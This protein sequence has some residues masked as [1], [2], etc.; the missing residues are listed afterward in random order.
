MHEATNNEFSFHGLWSQPPKYRY[1]FTNWVNNWLYSLL[2]FFSIIY[3]LLVQW[4]YCILSNLLS[5]HLIRNLPRGIK[6]HLILF[7][8]SKYIEYFVAR[9]TMIVVSGVSTPMVYTCKLNKHGSNIFFI[10]T[11]LYKSIVGALQMLHWP[12]HE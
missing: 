3:Y 10:D 7:I 2:L 8:E 5:K 1:S 12:S 6:F 11:Q 9:E 4:F